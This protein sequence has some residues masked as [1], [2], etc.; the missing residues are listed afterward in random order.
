M[1]SG[2]KYHMSVGLHKLL[3]RAYEMSM[4]LSITDLVDM[5]YRFGLDNRWISQ[6]VN[7]YFSR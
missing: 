6:M 1:E 3:V 2:E 7:G 5:A 4:K